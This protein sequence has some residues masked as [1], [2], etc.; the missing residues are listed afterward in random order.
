MQRSNAVWYV[1]L[2]KARDAKKTYI[3]AT[4]DLD[5]RLDQHNRV[6]RGGARATDGYIW[7]RVLHVGPFPTERDALQFEWKFKR[8]R[9]GGKDHLLRRLGGLKKLMKE[10]RSTSQSRDF[11]EFD[12]PLKIIMEEKFQ[13]MGFI[14][15]KWIGYGAGA[16]GA[17]ADADAAASSVSFLNFASKLP[18]IFFKDAEFSEIDD[19]EKM[20]E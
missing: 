4:I 7:D 1:Y 11:S 13:G 10:G 19:L 12:E 17:V 8:M 5:R 6:M 2:L 18:L 14:L 15:D 20:D 3:G 9:S 16:A